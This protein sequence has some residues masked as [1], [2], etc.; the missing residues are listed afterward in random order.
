MKKNLKVKAASDP[1]FLEGKARVLDDQG[2]DTTVIGFLP[3]EVPNTL[4]Y[5]NRLRSGELIEVK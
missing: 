1:V 2:R 5:R 4:Y 3:V